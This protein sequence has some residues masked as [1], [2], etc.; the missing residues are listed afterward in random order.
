MKH[1][2]NISDLRLEQRAKTTSLR[3]QIKNHKREQLTRVY[4]PLTLKLLIIFTK[5]GKEEVNDWAIFF[6][7]CADNFDIEAPLTI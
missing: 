2:I 4:E 7:S 1:Y 5:Y 6:S 3:K